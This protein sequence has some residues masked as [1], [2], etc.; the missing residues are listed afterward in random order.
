MINNDKVVKKYINDKITNYKSF[1]NQFEL[2]FGVDM[3]INVLIQLIRF[4]LFDSII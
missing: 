3:K 4:D 1:K 2:S